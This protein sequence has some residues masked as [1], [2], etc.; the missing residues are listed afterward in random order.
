MLDRADN[1]R[2]L[3]IE[4][5]QL[6]GLHYDGL[7]QQLRIADILLSKPYARIEINE[8]GITNVQQLLLPQPAA[9]ARESAPP[10]TSSSIRSVPPRA[11]CASPIAA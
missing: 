1:Q 10:R 5:L 7:S 11:T 8:E 2:L 4:N 3:Q 9:N 6:S